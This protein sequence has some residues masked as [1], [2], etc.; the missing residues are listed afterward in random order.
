[1]TRLP[2]EATR[3]NLRHVTDRGN[4]DGADRS[5]IYE[6]LKHEIHCEHSIT[7]VEEPNDKQRHQ[8]SQG[9]QT[10]QEIVA[11]TYHSNQ[12]TTTHDEVKLSKTHYHQSHTQVVNDDNRHTISED[13]EL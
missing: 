8:P 2:Q 5:Y 9:S 7:V 1:M 10:A 6:A 4:A 11:L 3:S 13:S 12:I